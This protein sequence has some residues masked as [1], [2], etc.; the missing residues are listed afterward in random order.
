[1]DLKNLVLLVVFGVVFLL[2]FSARRMAAP[3]ERAAAPIHILIVITVALLALVSIVAG[4]VAIVHG[5]TANTE[6]SLLG[7]D[8]STGDVGVALV[9]IGLLIAYFTSRGVLKSCRG[10][11]ALSLDKSRKTRKPKKPP[12]G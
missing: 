11:A 10:L 8:L 2:L 6:F 7:A 9:G 1:M 4:I 3:H 12:A 5:S